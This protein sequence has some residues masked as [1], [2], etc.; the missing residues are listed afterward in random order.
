MATSSYQSAYLFPWRQTDTCLL[1]S[2]ASE[3]NIRKSCQEREIKWTTTKRLSYLVLKQKNPFKRFYG[4]MDCVCCCFAVCCMAWMSCSMKDKK[5]AASVRICVI[6][7]L[8]LE[9][10]FQYCMGN[11]MNHNK[12][13]FL[14]YFEAK[15][16]VQAFLWCN[17]LWW[18]LLCC[19]LHGMV[20][21]QHDRQENGRQCGNMRDKNGVVRG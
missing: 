8:S 19:L 1:G 16:S 6:K 2:W 7:K 12:T 17:R 3:S 13:T 15:K 4:A 14:P 11:K 18:L 20:V 9:V 10:N 5:M 21:M